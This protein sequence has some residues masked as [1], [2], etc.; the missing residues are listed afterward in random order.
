MLSSIS[1]IAQPSILWQKS[2]NGTN[3]DFGFSVA[4]TTDGGVVTVGNSKSVN[5]GFASNHG[6][7]DAVVIKYDTQGTVIWHKMFGGTLADAAQNVIATSDGGCIFVGQTA[8]NDGDISGNHGM[9]DAWVMKLGADGE[10]QWQRVM[11]GSQY[12]HANTIEQTPDGGYLVGAHTSSL[13]GDVPQTSGAFMNAWVFRLNAQGE[14]TW[15]QTYP[16]NIYTGTGTHATHSADGGCLAISTRTSPVGVPD[17]SATVYYSD[18]RAVKYNAEGNVEWTRWYGGSF[19]EQAETVRA[20]SD[21]G[22]ILT[23][24]SMSNDGDVSGH[25]GFP[26]TV[27]SGTDD[28][29]VVKLDALGNI[30][31]QKSFGG[32]SNDSAV[33]ARQTPDG[34]YIVLGTAASNGSDIVGNHGSPANPTTDFWIAKLSPLGVIQWSKCLGGTSTELANGI[35]LASDNGFVVAGASISTN[36]DITQNFGS[37]DIWTVKLGPDRL[38]I[39]EFA[40]NQ[41]TLHPNPATD[42]VE[43]ESSLTVTS[44]T[45]SDGTGRIVRLQANSAIIELTGLPSGMY[46]ARITTENASHLVKIIKR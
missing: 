42:R 4:E 18:V 9:T 35:A 31:W 19:Q 38:S 3:L 11:G 29:W 32:S 23:A 22:Y 41:I 26:T 16:T 14:T 36:G 34:G 17:G 46:F 1:C 28:I 10:I 7:S 21:G 37:Y 25:H 8:S 40:L 6:D 5:G 13:N 24:S 2:G 30:Q 27:D 45:I 44:V 15:Q 12:D 39:H 33:D 20:T 43:I